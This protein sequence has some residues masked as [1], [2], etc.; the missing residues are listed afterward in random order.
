MSSLYSLSH[1][2]CYLTH[3]LKDPA[4]SDRPCLSRY[5][6]ENRTPST[7]RQVGATVLP[8]PRSTLPLPGD[9]PVVS[10]DQ[11]I[12]P[13]VHGLL[14][15]ESRL[16]SALPPAS[17]PLQKIY[18]LAAHNFNFST[19]EVR[20]PPRKKKGYICPKSNPLCFD[21]VVFTFVLFESR[22]PRRH[23]SLDILQYR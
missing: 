14:E 2:A 21:L 1:S 4:G 8:C 11:P 12:S 16:G 5:S 13:A 20:N 15:L 19:T 6:G 7:G 9:G 10:G 17:T 23:R 18:H 3:R 22:P